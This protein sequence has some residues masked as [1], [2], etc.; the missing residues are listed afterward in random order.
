VS[1][2]PPEIS[3][4]FHAP[5][6]AG[7]SRAANATGADAS[8]VC[9]SLV[10][11]ALVID[12]DSKE[13]LAAKFTTNGCGYMTAAADVLAETIRHKRLVELHGLHD[14]VMAG[15]IADRLG[16]FP[17]ARGQCAQVCIA[18][19]HKA[20]ADFRTHQIE[21]WQGEKA[22]ICTC[23]GVSEE[24]IEVA[25][26]NRKLLTVDEVTEE[27][28]AGGGCGSCRPLIQDIL[29]SVNREMI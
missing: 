13:I 22:L 20:L 10:R 3:E 23:F 19:L 11:F 9:G 24:T 2:Y 21:E 1:F 15:W 7:E 27:C 5:R 17:K 29:D 6:F 18:A 28:S 14:E 25:I 8:F 26:G 4:R 12:P 16:E